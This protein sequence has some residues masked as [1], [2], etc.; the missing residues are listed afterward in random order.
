[1]RLVASLFLADDNLVN[2]WRVIIHNYELSNTFGFN[3]V[4]NDFY[5]LPKEA[6]Y[7]DKVLPSVFMPPLYIYFIYLIK[8]LNNEFFN[9]T[10]LIVYLQVFISV[11]SIILFY[12]TIKF[13]EM[14]YNSRIILASIFAFYPLNIF[15]SVQISSITLQIFLLLS[16]F[17]F[18][19][20]F[21]LK[22]KN[23]DLF[24]F[25]IFSGLLILIRGEFYLIYFFSI[26]YFFILINKNIKSVFASI[27]I[28]L[29]IISPYLKRNYEIFDN[30]ILTKS[31]G[32]NLLKGNNPTF[33]VEGNPK[34]I[35]DN[36]NRKNLSI[37]TDNNYEI[38][39]DNFYKR[40]AL[41]FIKSDPLKYLK[42]YFIKFFSFVFFDINSTYPNYYNPLHIIP[43]FIL[44]LLSL[45]GVVA[46][47]KRL[48]LE[49]YLTYYYLINISLFALFFILPRYSLILLPVQI[50]LSYKGYKYLK[51][52][53]LN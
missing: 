33:K 40:K 3:V 46:S 17:L 22:R 19:F 53:L 12:E 30:I 13:F 23:K 7:D 24:L 49:G 35:E 1:M 10:Y 20:K 52:K 26:F 9:L 38:N 41:E 29:L 44:S 8:T 36:F 18:L 42:F 50:L 21:N 31:F 28:V 48:N 14:T 5:A 37:R 43:K 34:F 25:S 6:N 2:E 4:I 11:I 27:F 15:A 16:F 51:G 47:M 32:Y 45:I 39:L